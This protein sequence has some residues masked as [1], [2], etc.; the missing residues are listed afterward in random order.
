MSRR[1]FAE[2]VDELGLRAPLPADHGQRR[3]PEDGF[4]SGPEIGELLPNFVLRDQ[5]GRTVDL[6]ADRGSS[7]AAVVFYRSAVW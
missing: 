4:F 2:Y 3:M 1:D 6:H 7:K 5:T